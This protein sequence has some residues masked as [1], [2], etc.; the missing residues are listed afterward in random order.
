MDQ[1]TK[2]HCEGLQVKN[3]NAGINKNLRKPTSF[4][5]ALT[6]N[7]VAATS[8]VETETLRRQSATAI[9]VQPVRRSGH[10]KSNYD[11]Q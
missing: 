11:E 1:L 5:R 6:A 10:T 2:I 7:D 8:K 3:Q 4:L 9:A